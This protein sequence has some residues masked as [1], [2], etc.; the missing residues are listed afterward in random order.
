MQ[1]RAD[2]RIGINCINQAHYP[3]EEILPGENLRAQILPAREHDI[4]EHCDNLRDENIQIQFPESLYIV[5]EVVKQAPE[6]EHIP[7]GIEYEKIF[8]KRHEIIQKAVHDMAL[9]RRN[10]IFRQEIQGK[11]NQPCA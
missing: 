2:P 1:G 9:F 5:K 7:P 3:G 4:Y 6:Y 11:I 8:V 10:Q